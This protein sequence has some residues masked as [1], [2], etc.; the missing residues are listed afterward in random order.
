MYVEGRQ[1]KILSV[2]TSSKIRENSDAFTILQSVYPPRFEYSESRVQQIAQQIV[3]AF[4]LCDTPLL[5][6]MIVDKDKY[7]VIEFS[8]RMDGGSKYHLINVLAGVDIMRVYVNMVMG[9]TS[10]ITI[11]H[12]W[13]NAVM[14]YV[15]C[16]SGKYAK[17]F[18]F[19]QMV[20][21]GYMHSFF[22]YKMP[23]TIIERSKTSS[24]RVAGYLVV[25]ET[26]SDVDAKLRYINDHVQVLNSLGVDIMRHDLY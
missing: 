19:E 12:Q 22:E 25:G 6:Q 3:D 15:Y 14:I 1:A 24:D 18:N 11:K 8:A 2:T 23:N 20:N 16:K 26:Q 21:Q 13:N 4:D 17:L 10:S 5:V 9:K 7:N